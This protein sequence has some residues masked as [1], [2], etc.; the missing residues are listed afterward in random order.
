[1][2]DNWQMLVDALDAAK[3]VMEDGDAMDEDIQPVAEDLLNAILAQRFKADKSILE[4]LIAK[5]EAMDLNGYNE[6]SVGAFRSA[7]A[8]AQAVLADESLTEDDQ[9]KVDTAVMNLLTAME[10]LTDKDE[11]MP[12]DKPNQTPAPDATNTPDNGQVPPTGDGM[13]LTVYLLVA[14][15]CAAGLAVLAIFRKKNA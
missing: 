10:N 5:A 2:A 14:V 7:L 15:V 9:A 8:A 12:T 6:A 3:K 13:N 4:E 1:M 11:E